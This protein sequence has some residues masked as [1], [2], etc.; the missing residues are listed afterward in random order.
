MTWTSIVAIWG[1]VTGTIGILLQLRAFFHDRPRLKVAVSRRLVSDHLEIEMVNLGR[2]TIYTDAILLVRERPWKFPRRGVQRW[3]E[4]C[5]EASTQMELK[6]GEGVSVSLAKLETDLAAGE[7]CSLYRVGVVSCTGKVWW[8]PRAVGKKALFADGGGYSLWDVEL[9]N[10]KGQ[11]ILYR[12]SKGYSIAH[13]RPGAA[14]LNW[15]YPFLWLALLAFKRRWRKLTGGVLK[16]GTP[17]TAA[18]ADQKAPPSGR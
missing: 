10:G 13:W 8:S 9:E 17:N 4:E 6:E 7:V 15:R 5:R 18:P 16:V 12:S 3:E 1:A 14:E 2:R 11:L